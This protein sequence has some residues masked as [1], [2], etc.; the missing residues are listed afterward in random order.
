MSDASGH[1]AGN[2]TSVATADIRHYGYSEM[3]SGKDT[4]LL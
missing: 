2:L 1:W 4:R 3:A